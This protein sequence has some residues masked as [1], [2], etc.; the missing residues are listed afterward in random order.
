[1]KRI[2]CI[3]ILCS[4]ATIVEAQQ[5]TVASVNGKAEC[6]HFGQWVGLT[7]RIKVN[8]ADTVRIG[9]NSA[10]TILDYKESKCYTLKS[11]PAAPL[12][13]IIQ[14]Q[15]SSSIAGKFVKYLMRE[16]LNGNTDK[17]DKV[18]ATVSYKD[19]S[20]DRQIYADITDTLCQSA[21]PVSMQLIDY[22]TKKEIQNSGQIGQDFFFR[23]TNDADKP[24]YVNVL[25]ISS[26]KSYADCLPIDS[27]ETMIHFLIPAY[28]TLDYSE[29]P[30]RFG[31]PAGM[32]NLTLVAFPQ[33]F[34]LRR[35][36]QLFER[37]EIIHTKTSCNTGIYKTSLTI[38]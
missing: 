29:Y 27:A 33:P 9:E 23:I 32:D 31:Q 22:N 21:Y 36:I 10:L 17:E 20:A 7:N 6:L 28:S 18:L 14:S 8:G 12:I 13:K 30:Q 2:I 24:L 1:M 25:Y 11:Q 19:V 34:D 35:I 16:L 38:K 37:Q 4:L 26:D 5:F 3:F 15:S